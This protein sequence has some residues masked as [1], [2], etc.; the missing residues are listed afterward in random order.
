VEVHY[1]FKEVVTSQRHDAACRRPSS[2]GMATRL[3]VRFLRAPF[4]PMAKDKRFCLCACAPLLPQ[5]GAGTGDVAVASCC[6][7]LRWLLFIRA[8][9]M[10][11]TKK[12]YAGAAAALKDFNRP[13]YASCSSG[14]F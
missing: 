10:L 14:P 7:L 4:G 13:F 11:S 12:W 1:V 5:V 6:C 8:L 9:L 2:S 3:P